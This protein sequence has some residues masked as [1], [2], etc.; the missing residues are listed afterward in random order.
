MFEAL[1]PTDRTSIRIV[2]RTAT[3]NSFRIQI[4]S[5]ATQTRSR[6]APRTRFRC[7]RWQLWPGAASTGALP[8]PTPSQSTSPRSQPHPDNP[9]RRQPIR[10]EKC[11]TEKRLKRARRRTRRR[12]CRPGPPRVM[13]PTPSART[14]HRSRRPAVDDPSRALRL[15]DRW[16]RLL[17]KPSL[18]PSRLCYKY[19]PMLIDSRMN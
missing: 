2:V 11:L 7:R 19:C 14:Q 10:P 9:G 1:T 12:Q 6:R 3:N 5:S 17:T 18:H 4:T 8:K 16:Q 15:D 13:T